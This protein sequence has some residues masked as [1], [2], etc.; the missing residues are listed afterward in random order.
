MTAQ[1]DLFGAATPV[2]GLRYVPEAI[3]APEADG[4]VAF[5]ASLPF[6]PFEF[7]G[8]LGNRRIVSYG[9]HYDFAGRRLRRTSVP[10]DSLRPLI[11]RA[12]ALLS[13]APDR[14]EHVLVTEYAPGAGIGWHRDKAE[15]G[16][17]VAFSFAAPCRLRFRLKA[18]TSWKRRC[19]EVAPRS[20]YVLSGPARRAWE[21]SI[22]PMEALRYSVTLRTLAS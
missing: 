17:V 2:P 7:H 6:A 3:A 21:H 20:A 18:G 22:A 12:A 9:W 14:I 5:L 11:A 1:Q 15:F 10:P 16:D 4:L 19:L 8:H 13:V